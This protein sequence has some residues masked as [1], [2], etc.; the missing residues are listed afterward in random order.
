MI[1]APIKPFPSYKWRWLSV[2]P[3][4]SL[5]DPPVFLGVLRVLA[6]HEFQPPSS[7]EIAHELAIVQRETQTPVN[8]VRTPERNLVRNSGQY[9]KGTGLLKP[10]T[11]EIELT[12]LGHLLADGTLTQN[13]FAAIMVQQTV[14]PNP[15]TY[16]EAERRKWADSGLEIR[17]LALIIQVLQALWSLSGDPGE[18]FMTPNE[19]IKLCIPLSGAKRDSAEIAFAISEHRAGRLDVSEWPDCTPSANDHR[20]AKEFLLFLRNYGI[21]RHI[22]KSISINDKYCLDEHFN[23]DIVLE[24]PN[25]SIFANTDHSGDI[26]E[27]VRHS[28][29]PS[30]IE[31]QR[32]VASV[33]MRPRQSQFRSQVF[34]AFAGRCFLSGESIGE[35]LEAAH[36]VPVAYN[37]AD[38][39]SNSVCLRVDLH[40][41]FD[42]SNLRISD[43][44]NILKSDALAASPN[45]QFLP[46]RVNLPTFVNPANIHWRAKYL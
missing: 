25:A 42:S 18:A 6:R 45:Y 46:A 4:E 12:P 7:A 44:G 27:A 37:G 35:V 36:I 40:R 22:S 31:R 32:A 39:I 5:L 24:G 10:S 9:W 13:E 23:S 30:I 34:E 41:L 1:I 3:T 20:L 16:T 17:P 43:D 33:L 28:P 2:A 11:G 14:L 8:L 19:L 21:C 15:W 38:S 29:L 26:V